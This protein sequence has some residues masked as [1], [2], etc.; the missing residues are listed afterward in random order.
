M[1]KQLWQ[2]VIFL[3]YILHFEPSTS[4]TIKNDTR[5]KF[6]NLLKMNLVKYSSKFLAHV[7]E[8]LGYTGTPT[9]VQNNYIKL[10]GFSVDITKFLLHWQ[11]MKNI[12]C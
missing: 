3:K 9:N 5:K 8:R 6:K 4:N 2:L 10:P 1:E 12:L 7:K 11:I